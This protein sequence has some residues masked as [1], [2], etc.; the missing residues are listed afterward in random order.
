VKLVSTPIVVTGV[1]SSPVI[2]VDT[3][4]NPVNAWGS[5]T[6]GGASTYA[7]QYTTSDVFA[8]GY[9]V[10]GDANWTTIT[11]APTTGSKPFNLTAIGATGLR[12]NV[13]VGPS[14]VTINAVFQS[15]ST[16]GA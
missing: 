13:T 8:A 15:D 10:S 9:T 3:R 11:G 6:D 7:I 5:V 12:V 2:P 14:T 1:A 4:S 16:Q